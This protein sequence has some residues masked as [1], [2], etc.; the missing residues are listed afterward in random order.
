M[1]VNTRGRR[2]AAG[3]MSE[4]TGDVAACSIPAVISR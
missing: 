4:R 2:L 3:T 1:P